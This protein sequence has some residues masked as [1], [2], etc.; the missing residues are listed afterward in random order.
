MAV[1]SITFSFVQG[2]YGEERTYERTKK[3]DH[4]K[5]KAKGREGDSG[6][7]VH[8]NSSP[9]RTQNRLH[10]KG[11]TSNFSIDGNGTREV[12]VHMKTSIQNDF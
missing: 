12:E 5:K 6:T 1:T 2:T 3:G 4:Q 9:K 11:L 8:M 7:Q 10:A